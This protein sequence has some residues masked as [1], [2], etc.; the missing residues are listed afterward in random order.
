MKMGFKTEWE[1]EFVFV[2][3]NKIFFYSNLNIIK[4]S[5]ASRAS[6]VRE[7]HAARES[8]FGYPWYIVTR[9]S[10]PPIYHS[11]FSKQTVHHYG[12]VFGLYL[13]SLM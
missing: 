9:V 11:G 8:S 5:C 10:K 7:T 6:D 13:L 4:V 1:E 2:E 3:I 12:I